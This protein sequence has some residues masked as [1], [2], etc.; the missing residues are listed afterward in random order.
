M[1][2]LHEQNSFTKFR[3]SSI[4]GLK[5]SVDIG[6]GIDITPP[7]KK[8]FWRRFIELMDVSLLKDP[9][10]LNILFGL[11]IF[12]VAEMNFKMVTPF[13]FASLGYAKTDV[14]YCLS[15]RI[16][17]VFKVWFMLKLN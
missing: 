9:G 16:F 10:Y 14:A 3:P 15:V 4:E 6:I 8:G 12:Y 1:S 5:P 11:S 7:A 13:F 17:T 2:A